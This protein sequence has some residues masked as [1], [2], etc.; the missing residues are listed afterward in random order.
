MISSDTGPLHIATAFEK[1]R[2]IGFYGAADM[3]RT[4][5]W[6]KKHFSLS[7][8][9]E[10]SPCC[11]RNCSI[12]GYETADINPCLAAIT[13]EMVMEFIENSHFL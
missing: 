9:L 12:K 4:G 3:K 2:C 11:N 7:A 8:N 13:P 10:C 6:G 5:P 1:P